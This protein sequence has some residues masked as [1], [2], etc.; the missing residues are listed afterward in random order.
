M[1]LCGIIE[2]RYDEDSYPSNEVKVSNRKRGC[3]LPNEKPSDWQK[4]NEN[5]GRIILKVKIKD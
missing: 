1:Y 4:I 5:F 2:D 3:R